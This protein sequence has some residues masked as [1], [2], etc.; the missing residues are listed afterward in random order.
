MI[1]VINALLAILGGVAGAL[2]L[3]WVLN[4]MAERLPDEVGGP[5]QAVPLHPARASPRSALFL[6][7]PAV[8]TIIYSFANATSHGVGRAEE[9]HRPADHDRLPDQRCST[10]CSGSS[11]CPPSPS[12]SAWGWRCWPTG[13]APRGEKS[14]RRSSS[15]RWR[16]A[17][18]GAATIWRFVYEAR[19]AGT[20]PDRPAERRS[21]R[22][23]AAT[24]SPGCS[25][26]RSTSTACC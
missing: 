21:G 13:S 14:P 26:A 25:R 1:K 24:R 4:K 15:C 23:S 19:P 2:L 10:R 9:L 11:S 8:Q 18:V 16:S 6:I 5:G 20:A 7:Y 17:C 22:V 12:C 3:Y